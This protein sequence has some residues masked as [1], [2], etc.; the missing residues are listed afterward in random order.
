MASKK[1]SFHLSLFSSFGLGV[2]RLRAVSYVSFESHRSIARACVRGERRSSRSMA[3]FV[4]LQKTC[5][6][7][8]HSSLCFSSPFTPNLI[9]Y[10][11]HIII[12]GRLPS[13]R[14]QLSFGYNICIAKEKLSNFFSDLLSCINSN[15]SPLRRGFKGTNEILESFMSDGPLIRYM[16]KEKRK[17]RKGR[18]RKRG[19]QEYARIVPFQPRALFDSIHLSCGNKKFACLWKEK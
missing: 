3:L 8:S 16:K 11:C 15:S 10:G 7:F 4:V 17:K 13:T 1:P 2:V 6:F 5:T 9:F 18:E 12:V 19:K 14:K